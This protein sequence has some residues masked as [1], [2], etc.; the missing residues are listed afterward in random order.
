[1][2]GELDELGALILDDLLERLALTFRVRDARVVVVQ[3]QVRDPQLDFGHAPLTQPLWGRLRGMQLPVKPK[4]GR[5]AGRR[6]RRRPAWRVVPCCSRSW[7]LDDMQ[8]IAVMG[9]ADGRSIQPALCQ[10]LRSGP[11]LWRQRWKA[12]GTARFSFEEDEQRDRKHHVAA[13][14]RRFRR[15]NDDFSNS[16]RVLATH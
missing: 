2:L 10:S 16:I 1:M 5:P 7:N 13:I 8:P 4:V 11:V 3:N 6:P 12:A 15:K 14:F 9:Y